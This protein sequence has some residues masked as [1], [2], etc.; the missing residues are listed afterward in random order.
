MICEISVL[1]STGGWLSSGGKISVESIWD[2]QK[3]ETKN[4]EG[5]ATGLDYFKSLGITHVQIMPMYDF[6]SIDE[7]A[8]KKREYNWGYDPLNY[9]VPEGS[10]STDPFHGGGAYPGNERNDCGFSQGRA[11]E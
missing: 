8:P 11:S 9:N 1:D 2:W 10:F 3:R 5:E 4:K 6:A 7:A